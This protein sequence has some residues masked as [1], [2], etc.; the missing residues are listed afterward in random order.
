MPVSVAIALWALE[1]VAIA[2]LSRSRRGARLGA[3]LAAA[4]L[5]LPALVVESPWWQLAL[6]ELVLLFAFFRAADLASDAATVPFRQR[7]VHLV[8]VVDSRKA[9]RIAPHFAGRALATLVVASA[10]CAA[11]LWIVAA[12]NGFTGWRHWALRWY[13]GG[14]LLPFALFEAVDALLVFVTAAFGW[15]V[16]RL[17]HAPYLSTTLSEFWSRRWNNV[18]NGVLRDHVYRAFQGRGA[19][20]AASATFVASAAVHAYL[21]GLLLGPWMTA[22]WAAFFL[23]QPAL[24]WLER[25]LGVKR[26]PN[27][28]GRVWT[29]GTLGLLFPLFIEPVLVLFEQL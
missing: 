21:V 7:L 17:N 29:L 20:V 8:A 1:V 6:L 28:W 23:A 5:P 15:R 10:I 19:L 24:L 14:A 18:V 27:P 3:F 2:A 22:A 4:L 11:A 25:R 16:Q 13:A 12:A 26:W 9:R